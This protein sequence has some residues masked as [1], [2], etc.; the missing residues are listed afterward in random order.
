MNII[1]QRDDLKDAL[2]A[3]SCA[4]AKVATMPILCSVLL[5]AKEGNVSITGSNTYIGIQN[6]FKADVKEPGAVAVDASHFINIVKSLPNDYIT[7]K[8]NLTGSSISIKCKSIKAE[9][10]VREADQFPS[11]PDEMDGV[12]FTMS[13]YDF[14]NQI[15]DILFCSLKYT[16]GSGNMQNGI[17]M[18]LKD[19]ELVF[20][21]LDGTRVGQ[22]TVPVESDQEFDCTVMNRDIEAILKT[23]KNSLGIM[24][25]TVS[26][27]KIEMIYND[28]CRGFAVLLDGKYF[29]LQIIKRLPE[30]TSFE[31]NRSD[32]IACLNRAKLF[33]NPGSGEKRALVITITGD[34]ANF[35]VNS[36]LG[37]YDE[38]LPGKKEGADL[39]I[40]VNPVFLLDVLSK[41]EDNEVVLRFGSGREPMNISD[42]EAGY[43]YVILPVNIT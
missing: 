4:V 24:T 32:M 12:T 39:K 23:I 20:T 37:V 13:Q 16:N 1:C 35:F 22:R 5:E 21:A 36:T 34:T 30:K 8:T 15:S 10:A 41:I 25:V 19:G 42:K 7:I 14:R 28:N 29:D 6:T 2:D 33:S 40:G 11:F 26:K 38:E 31:F 43:A 3:A 18:K 27:N 9:I 17:N